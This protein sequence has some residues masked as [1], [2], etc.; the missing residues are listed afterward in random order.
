MED[1]ATQP[2]TQPYADPR[3]IGYNNSGL[4]EQ[5]VAD[6][7]CILHPSSVPAHNA[8]ATTSQRCPQHILQD[9]DLE[10]DCTDGLSPGPNPLDVALRLSSSVKD[11]TMG[12]CF[13]RNPDRCDVMLTADDSEKKVSNVHFRIYLKDD[14]ILMLHDMSTNG[15]VVDDTRLQRKGNPRTSSTQMLQTGSVI[16]VVGGDLSTEIKFIVRIP[17][18]DGYDHRYMQNLVQ[19]FGRVR[20]L[21]ERAEAA[22]PKLR[23]LPL[24][25]GP[26]SQFMVLPTPSGN[27][28]GMHWSGG[29]VYNV[30]GQIGKGAFATVYRLATKKDGIVYAAKELDKR[31]FM[32]NGVLDLKV[33][34]EMQ[35]MK[36]LRHVS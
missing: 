19:Y 34:N 5:D 7:I 25:N 16:Q 33:E 14:G 26:G 8:V 17:P 32:K 12:F 20:K 10:Y 35:I 21:T 23:N 9:I 3:R 30:T 31:K 13:G 15:T 11:P 28:H 24:R 4:K 1:I 18:R 6:V 22:N 27:T 2:S 36:C 29:S